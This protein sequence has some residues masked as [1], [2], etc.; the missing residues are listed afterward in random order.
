MGLLEEA[1]AVPHGVPFELGKCS[2][3]PP[4]TDRTKHNGLLCCVSHGE[5]FAG[6]SVILGKVAGKIADFVP[7]CR[8]SDSGCSFSSIAC[9]SIACQK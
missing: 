7:M 5:L 8:K 9:L 2:V 3:K 4:A 6:R 1:P